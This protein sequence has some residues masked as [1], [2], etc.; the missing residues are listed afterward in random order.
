M[1]GV[2][3]AGTPPPGNPGLSIVFFSFLRG[4]EGVRMGRQGG[5]LLQSVGSGRQRLSNSF[6]RHLV[7]LEQGRDGN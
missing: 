4:Y 3:E 6:C 2:G 7:G 1:F 5:T